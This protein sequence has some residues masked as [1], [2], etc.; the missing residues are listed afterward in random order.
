MLPIQ[1]VGPC[2]RLGGWPMLS[3]RHF[4]KCNTNSGVID[5]CFLDR[6]TGGASTC[7]LYI[8]TGN[9]AVG[10][11]AS[12]WLRVPLIRKPKVN[13]PPTGSQLARQ[14][15]KCDGGSGLRDNNQQTETNRRKRLQAIQINA[16]IDGAPLSDEVSFPQRGDTH[17]RTCQLPAVDVER[18]AG[19]R[20][21][22][23]QSRRV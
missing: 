6:Q 18:C 2:K 12:R 10:S 19:P 22:R 15:S 11:H 7:A 21:P 13:Y 8:R 3:S 9:V 23:P 16:E 5:R 1:D 20:P 17:H 4:E 14:K